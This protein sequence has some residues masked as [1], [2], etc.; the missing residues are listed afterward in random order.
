MGIVPS[1][2]DGSCEELG[3]LST[4]RLL[5]ALESGS[6]SVP[7]GLSMSCVCCEKSKESNEPIAK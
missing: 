5:C 2:V 7:W 3:M 1:M 4:V 6:S